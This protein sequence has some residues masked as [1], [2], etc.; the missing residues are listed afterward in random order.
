MKNWK[1]RY[2]VLDENSLNYY[3]TDMVRKRWRAQTRWR[4]CTKTHHVA[5]KQ[6]LKKKRV[7]KIRACC[8]TC[9]VSPHAE[10]CVLN[11]SSCDLRVDRLALTTA[12]LCTYM[13]TP[14]VC[15]CAYIYVCLAECSHLFMCNRVL[16]ECSCCRV[17]VL[18]LKAEE[19]KFVSG[20]GEARAEAG[21]SDP[22]H[23]HFPYSRRIRIHTGGFWVS[24]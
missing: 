10:A 9:C 6:T 13:G 12:C 7:K 11:T 3:K 15:V 21:L 22:S 4:Q 19:G 2:F 18:Q 20:D 17:F 23:K 16:S 24:D 14:R 1:R 8:K 5:P